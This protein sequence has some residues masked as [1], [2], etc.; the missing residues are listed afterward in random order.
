MAYFL[1]GAVIEKCYADK[2]ALEGQQS[3]CKCQKLVRQ[4]ELL[5]YQPYAWNNIPFLTG[6]ILLHNKNI[7]IYIYMCS[8]LISSVCAASSMSFVWRRMLR[9]N[10]YLLREP[11]EVGE[12]D[13]LVS[14]G[15]NKSRKHCHRLLWPT[16]V[17]AQKA[18][19]NPLI[20]LLWPIK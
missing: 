2:W 5:W 4:N 18:D 14:V 3:W 12:E 20:G 8:V 11:V 15:R 19:R 13:G 9:R 1:W 7:Y 16:G 10:G 6:T 17:G